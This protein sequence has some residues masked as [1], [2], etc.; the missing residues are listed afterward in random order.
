M[1]R[2]E[3][4]VTLVGMPPVGE[5]LTLPASRPYSPA[6]GCPARWSAAPRS[7]ATSPLHPPRR[8]WPA[9]PRLDDLP[10]H[11]ARA[12]QR[13]PRPPDPLRRHP[14]R[15]PL[16]NGVSGPVARGGPAFGQSAG[17]P[18]AARAGGGL[19]GGEAV[20]V[21][22]AEVVRA[23]LLHG[24]CGGGLP[25]LQRLAVAV[26]G[27]TDPGV[28]GVVPDRYAVRPGRRVQVVPPS[29]ET[30]TTRTWP[31]APT[32]RQGR[33]GRAGP[34]CRRCGRSPRR[35][36]PRGRRRRAIG[37]RPPW[38]RPARPGA[39]MV[40]TL[41]HE[42][43]RRGGGSGVAAMCAGGGMAT[44]LVLDVPAAS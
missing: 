38:R 5:T 18:R 34:C 33:D 23:L 8:G 11:Q 25:A 39:R 10:P 13:R 42:L 12:D 16:A 35:A 21:G 14:H 15:R 43:R 2:A 32:G 41:T 28:A 29:S 7:C 4:T 24:G 37:R 36:A 26:D 20:N 3:G 6:S 30:A 44:A 31:A 1:A 22:I 17:L 40:L 19:P 9:R 27:V